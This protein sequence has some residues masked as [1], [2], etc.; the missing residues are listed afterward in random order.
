[1]TGKLKME[2]RP[3]G[4][5]TVV[6]S[7]ID[8]IAPTAE[9]KQID[10]QVRLD[11]SLPPVSGDMAR[12]QQVVTNLLENAIKFTPAHGHVTVSVAGSDGSGQIRVA[13]SGVGIEPAFLPSIFDL[14][15]QEEQGRTRTFGGLGLGLGIVRS[16]VEAHG[17]TVRAESAGRGKGSAFTVSLPLIKQSEEHAGNASRAPSRE[18]E[19]A[20]VKGARVLVVEDDLG[21]RDAL[22]RVLIRKG[23]DVRSADSAATA[24]DVFADFRPDLLVCDIAM[25][26][27]DGYSLLARIRALGA[28]RGGDV[29][30]VALTALAGDDDRR[31]ALEA[32][33]Q[34]HM[35]K[36]VDIDQLVTT[37]SKLLKP[38]RVTLDAGD[39]EP[40]A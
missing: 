39:H 12:L 25:A 24:M 13:D 26:N 18:E 31:R 11:E 7:A 16:L 22:T 29:P 28:E 21:T 9:E 32:G 14:F 34:G 40:V 2:R 10:L 23:A 4:L 20:N 33:F 19:L 37:V 36:P 1:V 6:R 5:A 15:S 38:R 35:V 30:A 8:A 27:E 17:G 3:V